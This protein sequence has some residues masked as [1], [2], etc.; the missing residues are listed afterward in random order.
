[1]KHAAGRSRA[2]GILFIAASAIAF[3]IM[4]IAARYA[5]AS[6]VDIPTLL[7]LRFGIA[8][9]GMIALVTV[10]G[11]SVPRGRDL[12]I[13][14]ALG[15]VGYAGQA[16]AFFAALTFAPAGVVALLLYTH[17]AVVAVLSA[18]LLH[19]HLGQRKL[20]ALVVALAGTALTVLP[21]I[22][23]SSGDPASTQPAGILLGL[24]AS[25]I[26]SGYIVINA[27][28]AQRVPA[29]AMAATVIAS[30]AVVF[31]VLVAMRGPRW[32][33]APDG[34]IA[35]LVIALVSTLAAI[36]LFFAGLRRIGPTRA[37]TL[38]TLEPVCT[39]TLAAIVL[40]ERI[41]PVQMLGG[42]LILLAVVLLAGGSAATRG[43]EPAD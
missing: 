40:G 25:A 21:A 2:L 1:M 24:L 33:A 39:V 26:Y 36:T 38:S 11:T 28:V 32:P 17:P 13:L 42:M 12:G 7:A 3:G 9:A 16:S 8:A 14:A 37:A 22:L 19:E 10:T 27:R 35:V 5:Y 29:S 31:V 41:L 43:D 4:A 6:G 23:G 34:W 20:T 18:W 15:A 30:A